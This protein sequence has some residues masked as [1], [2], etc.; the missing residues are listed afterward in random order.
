MDTQKKT[1]QDIIGDLARNKAIETIISNVTKCHRPEHE[2]LAQM[3][4][5]DLLSKPDDLIEELH[6][7]N[8]LQYFL[9][10]MVTNSINSKTSRFYYLF[11]KYNSLASDI[12]DYRE[13]D[14]DD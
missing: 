4:Y 8:S 2:D 5:L 14:T 9:A 3:L 12:D 10:R 11:G 1:K 13:E 7:R 6:T